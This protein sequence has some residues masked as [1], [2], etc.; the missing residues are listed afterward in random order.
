MPNI[1]WIVGAASA[2][3]AAILISRGSTDAQS[4]ADLQGK[5]EFRANL[6]FREWL[7][8]RKAE[9]HFWDE[10]LERLTADY[11]SY[12]NSRL[13][14]CLMLVEESALSKQ[15]L[16]RVS[17]IFDLTDRRDYAFYLAD[18][19]KVIVGELKPTTNHESF[20][21][22]R[23][24]FNNFVTSIHGGMTHFPPHQSVA[25]VFVL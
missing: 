5:C 15:G 16:S 18:E 12:H 24:E 8:D 21:K 22:T 14:H 7:E 19:N 2:V 11:H 6:E 10:D 1:R 25:T 17:F 4:L 13:H 20:C 23:D 9:A 3:I